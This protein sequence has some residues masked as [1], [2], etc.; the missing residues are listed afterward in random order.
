MI[1][2]CIVIVNNVDASILICL[3]PSPCARQSV[4]SFNSPGANG[5]CGE[6]DSLYAHLSRVMI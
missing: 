5:Y 4:I 6:D 2:S 1:K 3:W